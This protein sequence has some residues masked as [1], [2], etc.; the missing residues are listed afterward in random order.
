MVANCRIAALTIYPIKS[1]GGIA[2]TARELEPRGL[3]DDRRMMLVNFQGEF[4]TQREY[5]RLTL[6]QPQWNDSCITLTAPQMPPISFQPSTQG[7]RHSVEVW[8]DTCVGIDQG[9]EVSDWFTSYLN[10][11][12]RLVRIADEHPRKVDKRYAISSNDEVSFADGFPLLVISTA[13]LD[14]LNRRLEH[15]V[16]MR[17]FRP[18]VVVEGCAAFEE[19]RWTRVRFGGVECAVV[20]PCQRCQVITIDPLTGHAGKEPMATLSQYRRGAHGGVCFGQN[21]I[22][23]DTGMLRVGD[24][25]T[26]PTLADGRSVV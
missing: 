3:R 15:P 13:S 16:T 25:V 21:V 20:K 9:R 23:I 18:N 10:L 7:E 19:D 22:P 8:E 5:P 17:H 26:F 14:D 12:C 6:V 11:P 4:L 24:E 1:C 2:V